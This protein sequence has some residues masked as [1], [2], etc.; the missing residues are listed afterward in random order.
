MSQ[1][2]VVLEQM[3][4]HIDKLEKRIDTLESMEYNRMGKL[5]LMDGITAPSTT[6]DWA[7]I[8]VDTSTGDLMC[9]FGDGTTNTIV[10]DT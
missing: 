3:L 7:T 8:Y 2:E 10:V 6:S 9:K 1:I 5:L 4:R